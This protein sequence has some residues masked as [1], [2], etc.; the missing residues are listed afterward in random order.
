M[1]H[2]K[3]FAKFLV[4]LLTL[5]ML[6]GC[7]AACREETP[8]EGTNTTTARPVEDEEPLIDLSIGRE[9]LMLGFGNEG[10]G[11]YAE[12][13]MGLEETDHVVKREIYQRQRLLEEKLNFTFKWKIIKADYSSRAAMQNEITA[14][15]LGSGGGNVYEAVVAYNL[16]PYQYAYNGLAENMFGTK[17]L[18]LSKP[19]WP[20]SL[21][22][23][24]LINETIYAV[25][26]DND[27]GVLRNL[28]AM[29]FNNTLLEKKGLEDPYTLVE[30]D[31]WNMAKL[32]EMVKSTYEDLN[33]NTRVDVDGDLFGYCGAT[34]AKKDIWFFALGGNYTD[35][36]DGK[37][38]DKLSD[39]SGR[40]QRIIDTM[41]DFF[42][43]PDTY[44]VDSS[45]YKMFR[46]ERAV[47]YSTTMVVTE[48]ITNDESDIDYGV[49]PMP[50]LD[51]EQDR[52]YT[53]TH[54]THDA[55]MMPINSPDLDM[56]SGIIEL[57]SYLS[58]KMIGPKYFD[59]YV[60]LRYA[61]DERLAGMYDLVRE[62]IVFDLSYLFKATYASTGH[63]SPQAIISGLISERGQNWPE[64]YSSMGGVWFNCLQD[65]ATI[66]GAEVI[67]E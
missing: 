27:Y 16:N 6:A 19:W 26:E 53:M 36:E 3:L 17:Y 40:I 31:Q 12:Q 47:F 22:N 2:A 15:N 49:V 13:Y 23:E 62:S 10:G 39:K 38:I 24:I 50:K 7:F 46:E 20:Q 1:K 48:H 64:V 14:V 56:I 61:P 25:V 18:D 41:R 45:Q 30:N 32:S 29:F 67:A 28:M 63:N 66:Y 37:I 9:V 5:A 44:V 35:V 59:T 42:D 43:I 51:S 4:S 8:P 21:T 33:G 65:F 55:W 58:Y 34:A 54:N 52:Y 57:S 60:K 11:G